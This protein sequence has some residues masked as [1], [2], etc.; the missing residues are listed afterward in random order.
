[1]NTIQRFSYLT[2]EESKKAV[3]EL[4]T[5]FENERDETLGYIGAEELLD[6]FM[7]KVGPHVYNQ[8]I[9]DARD[10]L[11]KGKDAIDFE[12]NVLKKE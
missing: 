4:I 7:E 5:Y 1:M 10:A 6:F 11:Q 8:G 9:E 12:L 3:E 2:K